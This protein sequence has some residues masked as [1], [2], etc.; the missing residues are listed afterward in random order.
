MVLNLSSF[1]KGRAA[2]FAGTAELCPFACEAKGGIFQMFWQR[3]KCDL[4]FR[5]Q[6]IGW[7]NC[8][9]QPR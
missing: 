6:L 3:T 9:G 2:N 1:G 7:T 8:I 4:Q 5:S